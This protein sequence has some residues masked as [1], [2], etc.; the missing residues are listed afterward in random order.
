MSIR[1]CPCWTLLY[2]RAQFLRMSTWTMCVLLLNGQ[3]NP[4]PICCVQTAGTRRTIT[5]ALYLRDMGE[6]ASG[7]VPIQGPGAWK[8]WES[9]GVSAD[10][11][12]SA[13]L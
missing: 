5:D 12:F 9:P 3:V 6:V 4:H 1:S 11:S 10:V 8:K 2:S 13:N 7:I